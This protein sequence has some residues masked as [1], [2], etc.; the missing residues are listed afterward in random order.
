M[1]LIYE[2]FFLYI[3]HCDY[4][5]IECDNGRC[6]DGS[7]C[8]GHTDCDDGSDEE[9]CGKYPQTRA[10]YTSPPILVLTLAHSLPFVSRWVTECIV[11]Y[12]HK[13]N[14]D[15]L[16]YLYNALAAVATEAYEQ[17]NILV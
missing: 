4:Y 6:E 3:A 1:C 5:E 11:W 2:D 7:K 16:L 17:I 15:T 8:D 12:T 14:R 10:R 9:F 13:E